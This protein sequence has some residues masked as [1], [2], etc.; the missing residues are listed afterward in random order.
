[1][2][3]KVIAGAPGIGHTTVELTGA[4][5]DAYNAE[6]AAN[7][8]EELAIKW[9]DVRYRQRELI[10]KHQDL[11]EIYEREV[12]HTGT[13]PPYSNGMDDTKYQEWLTYFQ[14]IRAADEATYATPEEAQTALDTLELVASQP[15]TVGYNA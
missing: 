11:I 7:A 10:V 1:M 15:V 14:Q 13:T 4:E 9:Q 8:A 3:Q 2:V 5:L 6:V 12:A